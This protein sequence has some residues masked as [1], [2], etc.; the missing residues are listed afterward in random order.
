MA[1]GTTNA[2]LV[3]RAWMVVVCMFALLQGCLCEII[4]VPRE[5][6]LLVTCSSHRLGLVRHY[7]DGWRRRNVTDGRE[8][9]SGKALRGQPNPPAGGGLPDAR[10]PFRGGRRPPGNLASP[11]PLRHQRRREPWGMADDGYRAGVP[12]HAALAPLEARGV[13]G[14]VTGRG[15]T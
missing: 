2:G 5:V 1:S 8:R 6:D 11:Q 3:I 13:L 12:G 7:N 15:H 10:L 14:G 9:I 4:F